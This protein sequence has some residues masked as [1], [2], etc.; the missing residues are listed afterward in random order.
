MSRQAHRFDSSFGFA[1]LCSLFVSLIL[2]GAAAPMVA[3]ETGEEKRSAIRGRVLDPS[4]AVVGGATVHLRRA[5]TALELSVTTDSEGRFGVEGL[6]EGEYELTAWAPGFAARQR[7]V[8]LS[9]GT[10]HEVDVALEVQP[11]PQEVVVSAPRIA[12]DPEHIKQI[13]GSV[14]VVDKETLKNSH[15]VN[16]TEALRKVSGVYV[17]DDEGFGARPHISIRGTSPTRSTKVLLLEDGIPLA[18]AP[19]GD[20]ASYYHP[21]IDRFEAIEVLKGSG[22]ILY[23]PVTVAGVVNYLTP[24]P[25]AKPSGGVTLTGGNREY[26]DLHADYGWT[27][28]GTGVLLGFL[29]KQGDGARENVHSGINDVNFKVVSALGSR[30]ALTLRGSYYNEKSNVTYSGLREDEFAANPRQNPFKNDFFYGDRY[31]VSVTHAYV[32]SPNLLMTTNLYGA[33]FYRDWWRQSSNSGQ[34]PNDAAD[35][36]CGGM[37]NLNTTCGNEGRLRDY[38]HWGVEPRFRALTSFGQVRNETDFGF[39]LHYERQNRRQRNGATPTAR[40]GVFV[41]DNE[42]KNAAYSAFVQNR[43]L[44]GKWA[45]TPGLRVEHIEYERTNRLANGGQ[46]VSGRTSDT[47]LIPGIGVAYNPSERLS[48]FAGVHRGFAPART[49]DIISNSTGAVVELDPELSWDY[50]AGVRLTPANGLRASATFFRMDYENQIVPASVAG[51]VGATLTNGGETL[52]QGF[53]VSTRVDTGI[54]RGSKHNLYTQ[55]AY[56]YLPRAEFRGVRFSSV[57]G[58]STVSV[59]GNRLPY[60]PEHVLDAIVGYSHPMGIDALLE[61]V[62]TSRQFGDDLNTVVPT[63][64]GQRGLIP[65]Y[66]VWNLAFNYRREE[67]HST[68]FFT[69]KNLFDRLYIVDRTR[70]ILPG[71]PRLFQAG[72]RFDCC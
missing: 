69:V 71:Y 72:V 13:P 25:P 56:T 63:P 7:H 58:F 19:Y 8:V 48:V 34:R 3:E 66:A 30:H 54:L 45:V 51:G 36:A 42:R 62:V 65:G 10:V 16:F 70:G 55:V 14:E 59:S 40:T 18:Y 29:R 31:G 12:H 61:T 53:E 44:L 1:V 38:Y 11:L 9:A 64:D 50:E 24:N 20:N 28:K 26:L 33:L 41:E 21:P 17:R 27:W 39:R 60:A 32:L 37:A 35:P 43:F 22:Q 4:A 47:Q 15:P 49:E 5:G 67:L 23:G 6:I 2:L 52:H 68:F 46:G 57:P